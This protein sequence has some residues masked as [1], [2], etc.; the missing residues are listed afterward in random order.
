L[1]SSSELDG[2]GFGRNPEIWDTSVVKTTLEIPDALYRQAKVRAA[3]ENRRM[4][5]LVSDG[6]RM[7]LGLSTRKTTPRQRRMTKAPVKVRKGN[8]IPV[9]S[10]DAIADLLERS[11][12]RLP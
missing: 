2:M 3:L 12:E 5:D 7:V 9:L 10:N 1:F 8:V 4:K 6:L 11:G